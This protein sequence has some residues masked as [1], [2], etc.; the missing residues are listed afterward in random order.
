MPKYPYGGPLD[1]YAP[2]HGYQPRMPTAGVY[3]RYANNPFMAGKFF[4]A[5]FSRF[6]WW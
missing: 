5:K 3:G 1:F 6:I 2:P 4:V